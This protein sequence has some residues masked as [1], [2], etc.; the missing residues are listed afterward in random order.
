MWQMIT[1]PSG[2]PRRWCL[3]SIVSAPA[4][5]QRLQPVANS[6]GVIRQSFLFLV[7]LLCAGICAQREVTAQD[8]VLI[9]SPANPNR[10]FEALACSA[11]G[12][13]V[14]CAQLEFTNVIDAI[15][16]S[17]NW[18]ATWITN[19]I[20][21]YGGWATGCS[22]DGTVLLVMSGGIVYSSTNSGISWRS[23]YV[24]GAAWYSVAG[25]GDG[26]RW[27]ASASGDEYEKPLYLSQD[28]GATWSPVAPTNYWLQVASSAAGD[29]LVA[30]SFDGA[31]I[32]T[33][34]GSSWHW[35][36]TNVLQGCV[37]SVDGK[38]IT[39]VGHQIICRSDDFGSTW[40]FQSVAANLSQV[41]ASAD[42]K[43]LAA[44]S[45]HVP[46][47]VYLSSDGGETWTTNSTPIL[48]WR[49]TVFSADG[50]R[51]YAVGNRK[52][53]TRVKTPSPR[54]E[55]A[56]SGSNLLLAW[57]VPAMSFRLQENDNLTSTSWFD[58]SAQPQFNALSLKHEMIIAPV[59]SQ[60]F[61][62][63]SLGL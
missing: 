12:A 14:I 9:D 62:R 45:H 13:T 47:P 44:V 2:Q 29:V 8:W 21:S 30:V 37:C 31:I 43:E 1:I 20:P 54:V 34:G 48:N 63:L 61:Y 53:Y 23:N 52:I 56:R 49:R 5:L 50:S 39:L 55:V 6:C 19:E 38:K 60:K 15:F 42:Q 22:A 57:T 51:S 10:F 35:A 16:T 17:T 32:S 41:S 27:L 4:D 40:S 59:S 7:A 24:S 36:L 26:R 3:H 46:G 28:S 11:D 18:G 58:V 25:S 33:N